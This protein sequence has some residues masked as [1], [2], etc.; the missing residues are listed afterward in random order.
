MRSRLIG[1]VAI[2]A[3]LG[4]VYLLAWATTGPAQS[5]PTRPSGLAGGGST[6]VTSAE[7]ACQ[8]SA[9][10]APAEKLAMLSVPKPRKSGG[11]LTISAI[12][13]GIG[14]HP[15]VEESARTVLT[16]NPPSVGD[17]TSLRAAGNIAQGLTAEVANTQG[18]S[19]TRCAQPGS[20]MWFTG[21]GEATG[22][23]GV[24]LYL[25]NPDQLPATV[26]VTLMTDAG[27]VQD[28]VPYD[29]ITVPPG[30]TIKEN[31][32]SALRNADVVAVNVHATAGRVAAAT[33]EAGA[34]NGSGLWLPQ[35]A[36]PATTAVIPGLVASSSAARLFVVVPGAQNA[37]VK[38][39]ALT[40]QG[41]FLPF[42]PN[43]LSAPSNA[44]SVFTLNS[45]GAGVAGIELI[46]NVPVTAAVAVPGSGLGAVTPAGTPI[47][48]Q[49]VA[50]GNPAKGYSVSVVLSAPQTAA[51][52][53]VSVL[54]ASGGTQVT[55]PAGRSVAVTVH[56]PPGAV[57]TFPLVL[58][59]LNGSGPVYAARLVASGGGPPAI[60]SD[61]PMVS[62]P[63]A[64]TLAPVHQGYDAVLP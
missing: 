30:Q 36:E 20:D 55:V 5:A 40:P 45:L 61:L 47:S 24:E 39:V 64:V 31:L 15:T 9:A 54:A 50:A 26:S 17:A 29:G 34:G 14:D 44:A 2:V 35:T 12:G 1:F 53:G 22:A 38:V 16:V 58:T 4:A 11:E 46:A 18:T 63:V 57:G 32:T 28:D 56:A 62:T 25:M 33:W 48:Q 42:G 43:P 21:T 8:P 59:P 7:F 27:V 3:A 13:A 60:V 6:P 10:H 23:S 49:A 51:R 52:V 37:Q 41:R 19:M